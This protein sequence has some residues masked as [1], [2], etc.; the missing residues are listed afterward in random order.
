MPE[1]NVRYVAELEPEA[2][3]AVALVATA[4]PAAATS[5]T[6]IRAMRFDTEQARVAAVSSLGPGAHR[7]L[8]NV[9]RPLAALSARPS[10]TDESVDECTA[11][12]YAI[13]PVNVS[14]Y[15]AKMRAHS[16]GKAAI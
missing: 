10:S 9:L 15:G 3:S 12:N 11:R 6:R 1:P 5:D 4:T 14:K 8:T 7:M 13:L 2:D 16:D